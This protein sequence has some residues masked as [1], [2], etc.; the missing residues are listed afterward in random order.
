[1]KIRQKQFQLRFS[2]LCGVSLLVAFLLEFV[3]IVPH[4][5]SYILYII[6]Y[7]FGSYFM[8]HELIKA[9]KDREFNIDLLMFVA[10]IG[11]AFLGQFAE[12]ALLLFLFSMG[13]SLESY[14]LEK[15]NKSIAGL[16]AL[17][18]KTALVKDQDGTKE[19]PIEDLKVG[20][21]VIIKPNSKI[22]ADGLI[23]KGEST[24]DQSSLT[25]ESI[26]VYKK[27]LL[28][29]R[30]ANMQ[31]I[32]DENRV[33][34]GTTNGMGYLEVTVIKESSDS[35]LSRLVRMVESAKK[36]Q[37]HAQQFTEKFEKF[38]VP[39]VL[40]GV[41]F[42]NF[43][44]LIINEPF[45]AS[46]YRA[47]AVLVVSSPCALVIS[48][49]SAVLCGIARAARMGVLIKGGK[50][51]VDLGKLRAFAFDKTGTLTA[52]D[53]KLT[54]IITFNGAKESELLPRI[55]AVEQMSDHPLAKALVRDG[56]TRID[57]MQLPEVES[58]QSFVGSGVKAVIDG[59]QL[60]IGNTELFIG[61][62]GSPLP[63]EIL[64]TISDFQ[65]S[66]KTTIL[67]K[68]DKEFKAIIGLMDLPRKE[69]IEVI[70]R[71]RTMGIRRITMLSG[72]HQAVANS[73]AKQV[74]ISEAWGNLM[75]ED[76]VS[77]IKEL[78]E[79]EQMVA[80]VGD[81]VNDAPAMAHS[82]VGVAMGAAGS[83]IALETADVAL[84]SEKLD[85]LPEAIM[86]SRKTDHII[87]QNITISL[88]VI[89]I[90]IPVTLLGL[91]TIGPAV[92]IHEGSTVMV[93]L[94]ALRLLR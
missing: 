31:R 32:K 83:D 91:A 44:F 2:I 62:S 82:T 77:A 39:V 12:G 64:R 80:M 37:A 89:A 75:P 94:N 61:E 55:I 76:K 6:S 67:M 85:K 1:M 18:P 29:Y 21:I 14:A 24:V 54:D 34:S 4:L 51:L 52:G 56:L 16:A 68:E 88:G 22:A 26:P 19:V 72:D 43:A 45:S 81:G 41:F 5:A 70:S 86:L 66:G 25:G 17:A 15:A 57:G 33:Y 13:H 50:P 60:A 79:K 3:A 69:N 35:T 8:F 27:F 71:L 58:F 63:P 48:T 84:M 65:R 53:P 42:L 28:N 30:F 90:M 92:V 74:G 40:V 38:F 73:I 11:A 36:Q 49:P 46:F 78:V 7:F 10:A 87:R 20:D 9:L 93:V 47:M 23:V 59:K